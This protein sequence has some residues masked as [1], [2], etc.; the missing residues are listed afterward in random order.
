MEYGTWEVG[1]LPTFYFAN[2][3]E[4]WCLCQDVPYDNP[5]PWDLVKLKVISLDKQKGKLYWKWGGL[6]PNSGDWKTFTYRFNAEK[7]NG[8]WKI[9]YMEGFDFKK[10]IK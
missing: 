4:P 9:S 10:S 2:D 6:P 3:A 5:N 7:E 8:K 1:S